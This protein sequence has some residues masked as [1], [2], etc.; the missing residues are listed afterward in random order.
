MVMFTFCIPSVCA[1]EVMISPQVVTSEAHNAPHPSA[2]CFDHLGEVRCPTVSVYLL[3][4][5]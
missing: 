5:S 4:S 3:I 1:T 2:V